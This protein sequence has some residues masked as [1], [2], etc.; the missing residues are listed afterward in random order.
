MKDVHT[1]REI[2]HQ[3]A[4]RTG[5]PLEIHGSHGRL[6]INGVELAPASAKSLYEF[7]REE[8]GV[9]VHDL[10][11]KQEEYC[12]AN[13]ISFLTLRGHLFL[14]TNTY[15]LMLT[16]TSKEKQVNRR[17]IGENSR[18][19]P[20]TLLISPN[21][22]A[23]LDVLFRLRESSLSEPKSARTFAHEYGLVQ[24]KLSQMMSGLGAETLP[25]LKHKIQ[26]LPESWWIT[27]LGYPMTRKRLTPFFER[28]VPYSSK[29]GRSS[30]E[31]VSDLSEWKHSRSEIVFGPVDLAR[32]LGLVRDPDFYLW[33]SQSTSAELKRAFR[34]VPENHPGELTWFLAVPPDG[35]EALQ[36][37]AV[38]SPL[39]Y[40]P[41]STH[42]LPHIRANLFR[43]IW[44]LT[45]G[46][47]RLK[48]IR[49]LALRQVLHAKV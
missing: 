28:A 41:E 34:L 6:W 26:D 46:S 36:R 38:L 16:P 13:R 22:L 49:V 48:E 42:Y 7:S 29:S 23:I 8:L 4:K 12:R 43:A 15:A 2:A 14:A 44:D 27:A 21:G 1:F 32:E 24:S 18:L 10:S 31:L 33:A 40:R 11:D 47:E 9:L 30:Q 3:I 45:F 25:E 35:A 5:I 37:E 19:P 20:P 39:A 17:M